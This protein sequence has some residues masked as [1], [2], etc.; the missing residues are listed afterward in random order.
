MNANIRILTF[1]ISKYF[2]MCVF[3][4]M[5][6]SDSE[7]LSSLLMLI[8]KKIMPYSGLKSGLSRRIKKRFSMNK[9]LKH[10][11]LKLKFIPKRKL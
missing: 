6:F 7:R 2:I 3:L 9:I 11:S 8:Q 4:T 5:G 1:E 10:L